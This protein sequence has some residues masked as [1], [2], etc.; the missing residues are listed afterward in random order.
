MKKILFVLLFAAFTFVSCE[1]EIKFN[2]EETS[3][4]VVL[5]SQAVAGEPLEATISASM[6]FLERDETKH[7]S[8][9]DTLKGSVEVYVNGSQTPY[10]MTY[11]PF[12]SEYPWMVNTTLSYVSD[13]VPACGDHIRIVASFPGFDTVEGE[14]T[15]PFA[16]DFQILDIKESHLQDEWVKYDFS[17]R[18]KDDGSYTKYYYL[19]P[20]EIE[21]Y[22][23]QDCEQTY[24][25]PVGFNSSDVLFQSS[26]SE[27]EALI[28]G[29]TY[30]NGYFSDALISGK[31][32]DFSF[33]I[34]QYEYQDV[35]PPQ[36]LVGLSVLTESLYYHLLSM[37]KLNNDLGM[38]S[39]GTILYSNVKGGYG[40]VCASVSLYLQVN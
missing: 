8:L 2:G 30:T 35:P 26:T 9:L 22:V 29:G 36:M 39:E 21:T 37:S 5:Y 4:K 24:R 14:T 12:E 27:L 33:S 7:I 23:D 19:E 34:E 38:F 40:C 28:D 17:V 1:K 11:V 3:P 16:P 31:T 13:Y 10:K 20:C 15:V 18:L 6:F 25:M 32:H